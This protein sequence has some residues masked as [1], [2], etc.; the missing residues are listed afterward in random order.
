MKKYQIYKLSLSEPVD[1]AAEELKKYLRMMVP[2]CDL[3]EIG[4]DP[5]ATDGFRLGL[6]E[7]FGLPNEAEDGMLDDVVHVDTTEDG[8]ILAGSNP[9]SVLFAVYRFLKENGCRFLFPGTDG[10]YI[11]QK[12]IDPVQYHKMADYRFRAHTTEGGPSLEQALQY[13]D[14]QTKQELNTYGLAGI[15]A[16]HNRYYKHAYNKNR[17]PEPVDPHLVD[18][19]KRL[20]EVE[21]TKRGAL[22]RDGGH[23]LVGMAVGLDPHDRDLYRS[24]EKVPS[25]ETKSKL[26]MLNGV[27]DLVRGDPIYTNLCYSQPEVRTAY[28]RTIVKFVEENRQLSLVGAGMA[29][30]SHNHCECEECQKLRPSDYMIMI[31]NEVD[32]MLTEKGIDTKLYFSAYVD[33]LFAP[34]QARIKNPSR[35]IFQY[36]PISRHYAESITEDTVFPPVKP[37][38]RNKWEVPQSTAEGVSYF[39]EWQKVFP[40]TNVAYEYHYWMHQYRDPGMMAMS[41][42]IYEDI[43]SW[44]LLG[45][46]GGVEDG[47]NKSFF[48]N[49]FIDHILGATLWDR[50]LDYEAELADYFSHIYGKDWRKVRDYL[51]QM[52]AAFDHAYLCG[53]RSVDCK[54]GQFYNPEHAKS[55]AMV[56][57]IAAEGRELIAKHMNMPTRPQTVCWRLLLRHTQWCEGLADV[58][59]EKCQGR[60]KYALELLYKFYDEFGK[61][62]YEL[63]RYFDFELAAQSMFGIVRKMRPKIEL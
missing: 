20:C 14:Y 28:A 61:Y 62:D 32:E 58:F 44:K 2:D 10:E 60:D 19:W 52:S 3:I 39:K 7:E 46:Q 47:S 33:L 11:P 18:Q 37:Y 12:S 21:L 1:F 53:Q 31:M 22:I 48:P 42:R 34:S 15:D 59:M 16:Y 40:C 54:Q 38:I 5:K 49:G 36:A 35:F 45:L 30:T 57:E 13:I 8:G 4:Y 50:E 23:G 56:H 43:R 63:E 51:E 41:R 9:R 24:G 26:A 25:E 27:R 6:L 29:D 55:L 17:V